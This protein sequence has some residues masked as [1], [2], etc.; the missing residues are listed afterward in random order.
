MAVGDLHP[1]APVAHPLLDQLAQVADADHDPPPAVAGQQ[2]E[3]VKEEGLARDLDQR[4]GDIVHAIT[5]ARAEPSGE[6]AH[7]WE[8]GYGDGATRP[9]GFWAV[10]AA[11]LMSCRWRM[12]R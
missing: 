3:L 8:I 10:R 9:F 1:E 7:R 5:Q 2:P 11:A 6:D 12:R 4:L